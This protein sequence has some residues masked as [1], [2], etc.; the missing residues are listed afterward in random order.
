M[1]FTT[2][3]KRAAILSIGSNTT[4]I[5]AKFTVGFFTGSVSIISEAIHS[6]TD[7]LAALLAFYSV[8]TSSEPADME[9]PFG[10][11]KFEDLS[12][13]LEGLLILIAAGYIIY[14]AIEKMMSGSVERIET[15][16]GILVMTASVIINLAVSSHLFK[17]ARKTESLAL[18]ADAQ[19]LKADI[20]TSA[21]VL[22]GLILIKITGY[23]NLDPIIA[24]IVA[25]M[26]IKTGF[27]LCAESGK[28]LL[29]ASLPED[30][31]IIIREIVDKFMPNEVLDIQELK[32]RRAGAERLIEFTL[33]VPEN[34]TIKE[35]HSLCDRIEED[36]KKNINNAI[37]TIH[38]E[39]CNKSCLDCPLCHIA[40]KTCS[41]LKNTDKR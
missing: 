22:I 23:K 32:T 19:H 10:H 13:A 18:L 38:L 7:L 9:H 16:W 37:I 34:I 12:G 26:I 3:K 40:I 31:R 8:K 17:V 30:E 25:V 35:G 27:S 24:L 29:D 20:Y 36:L 21:G 15:F 11:G 39:P 41:G 6:F 4:L 14:E 1:N 5:L 28:N 2:I 33:T